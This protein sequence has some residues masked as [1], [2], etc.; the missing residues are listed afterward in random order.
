MERFQ[1]RGDLI[2]LSLKRIAVVTELREREN[3]SYE[4]LSAIQTRDNG[5][6]DQSDS[7]EDDQKWSACAFIF[8][9]SPFKIC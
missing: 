8:K 3:H 9:V 1:K 6:L 4:A 5:S 2:D 7:R